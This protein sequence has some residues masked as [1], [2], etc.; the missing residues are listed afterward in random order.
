[1][2]HNPSSASGQARRQWA[3]PKLEKLGT[4]RDVAGTLNAPGDGKSANGTTAP[5]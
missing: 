2:R 3:A 4:M 1:M 5:S